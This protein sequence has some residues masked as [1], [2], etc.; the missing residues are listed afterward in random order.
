MVKTS[1]RLQSTREGRTN[2][3]AVSAQAA[4][5]GIGVPPTKGGAAGDQALAAATQLQKIGFVEFTTRL[6]RDVYRAI[7][8][9]S[10]DQLKAYADFVNTVAKTLEEYQNEVTGSYASGGNL[11]DEQKAKADD[12]I[13]KV[14]GLATTQDPITLNDEQVKALRQEFV[15]VSVPGANPDTPLT[16][17]SA[18]KGTDTSSPNIAVA[19]LQQLVV[20]KL[21]LNAAEAYNLI[22][23]VLQIGMQKVVVTNGD[24]LT[25][26]VFHVDTTNIVSSTSM[27]I[28]ERG[29]SWGIQGAL[30]GHY[31]GTSETHSEHKGE[32]ANSSL[33]GIIGGGVSGN[34]ASSKLNVSVV[35]E[36]HTAATNV[37]VD[38]IGQV[39]IQFRT[40]T[41]PTIA[42]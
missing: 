8:E 11:S 19:D 16:I 13:Q 4:G 18:I 27:N 30:S 29:T 3:R 12:Y 41:F 7:V 9:A 34:Y 1:E 32:V 28:H 22:K 25:K 39:R 42:G 36:S 31:G 21:R 14:L 38:I 37:T 26:L 10:I 2:Q 6:V 15:G 17:D 5:V 20:A 33:G 35:N 40:E 23:T 24:I